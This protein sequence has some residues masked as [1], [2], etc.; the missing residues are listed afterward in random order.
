MFSK[1][2]KTFDKELATYNEGK[3]MSKHTQGPWVIEP[4]ARVGSITIT[5]TS[6][7]IRSHVAVLPRMTLAEEHGTIEANAALI[8]AAPTMAS[9]IQGAIDALSQNA[10]FPA[11][12]ARAKG[13]LIDALET[14]GIKPLTL[15]D[16]R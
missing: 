2:N 4:D 15:K 7:G 6:D 9:R 11:D 1:I 13:L 8:A 5:H 3:N 14:A 12:I 10:V 16:A